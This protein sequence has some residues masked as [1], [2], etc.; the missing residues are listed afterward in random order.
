MIHL[1]WVFLHGTAQ[2]SLIVL[3]KPLGHDKVVMV[4][5]QTHI[6]K[7]VF[8]ETQTDGRMMERMKRE[9]KGGKS[10][11]LERVFLKKVHLCLEQWID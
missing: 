2:K 3:C 7:E 10:L 1:T 9:K 5:A 11:K 4:Q 8:I 6:F